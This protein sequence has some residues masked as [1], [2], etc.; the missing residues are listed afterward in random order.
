MNVKNYTFRDSTLDS[1]PLKLINGA[2]NLLQY[3]GIDTHALQVEKIIDQ[4]ISRAKFDDFGSDSFLEPLELYLDSVNC[5][6][7][8]NTFGRIAIREM[9]VRS[10]ASRLRLTAWNKEH[11]EASDEVISK[12]WIIV[13]L[14]RTGTS[15]LSIL[16]GL[17]P[18]GRPLLHWETANPIPPPDMATAAEAP[19]I[20]ECDKELKQML[21][22]NPALKAMHPFGATLAQECTSLFMYDVRTTGLESQAYTPSFGKWLLNADM[23]PAYRIHKQILQA[24]QS[25]QPTEQWVLKSPNHLWCLQELLTAY[26]DARIIW[27][28]RKPADVVTSMASLANALQWPKSKRRDPRPVA[29]DWNF[30]LHSVI[31]KAMAFD[32]DRKEEWC[33]HLRYED[34]MTNPEGAI[35]KIFQHFD[36]SVSELHQRRMCKWLEYR[37]KNSFGKHHYEASDFGWTPEQLEEQYSDYSSG[38]C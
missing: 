26:P 6:A 16:L 1:T 7:D 24:L 34:L 33:Y 29:D 32:R 11:P 36:L 2:G 21:A 9:L 20:I 3:I 35:K 14:P 28:H 10:L 37:P 5:E 25:T 19:R 30:K 8:L 23:T 13:G 18:M 12:P 15:L 38:Y 27:T 31:N 17:N 22:I 4:A